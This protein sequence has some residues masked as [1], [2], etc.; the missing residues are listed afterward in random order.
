[1]ARA[2]PLRAPDMAP[3]LSRGVAHAMAVTVASAVGHSIFGGEKRRVSVASNALDHEQDLPENPVRFFRKI[4]PAIW[5]GSPSDSRVL[6]GQ[7]LSWK[8][9]ACARPFDVELQPS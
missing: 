2:T 1:M 6:A 8:M 3:R 5:A 7:L 4:L 9:A